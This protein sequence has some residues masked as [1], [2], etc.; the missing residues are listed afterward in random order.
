MPIP[1][2]FHADKF[3]YGHRSTVRSWLALHLPSFFA[4]TRARVL[5]EPRAISVASE[6]LAAKLLEI[7]AQRLLTSREP[8]RELDDIVAELR[9]LGHPLELDEDDH[10]WT[11]YA[12]RPQRNLAVWVHW[13]N[14]ARTRVGR[15]E[16]L[17][18]R[19]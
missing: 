4:G 15:T 9:A 2:D 10:S 12:D 13:D 8:R 6:E 17:W 19:M 5:G 1:S 14:A 18:Q 3:S 16:V 11:I 7:I